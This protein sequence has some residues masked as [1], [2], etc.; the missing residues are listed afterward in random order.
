MLVRSS[1]CMR[2]SQKF[3]NSIRNQIR[4]NTAPGMPTTL[5]RL[6]ASQYA[7]LVD[8]YSSK[9]FDVKGAKFVGSLALLPRA[10]FHWKV[11]RVHAMFTAVIIII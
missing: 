7:P 8:S 1:T 10:L 6:E 3:C 11:S 9:G 5:S 2:V 4:Y